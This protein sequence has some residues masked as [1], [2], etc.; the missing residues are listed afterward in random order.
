[1]SLITLFLMLY[2]LETPG[3]EKSLHS[4]TSKQAASSLLSRPSGE[5]LAEHLAKAAVLLNSKLTDC[6]KKSHT[7]AS[8]LAYLLL[9][10]S[11]GQLTTPQLH[12]VVRCINTQGKFGE[13]SEDGYYKKL[14]TS[15]GQLVPKVE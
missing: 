12:Y 5:R 11:P 3:E 6:G 2:L 1:M 15:F 10:S 8:F 4:Y 9:P 13:P 7:P 14:V